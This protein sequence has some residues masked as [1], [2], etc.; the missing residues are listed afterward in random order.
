[1]EA[2]EFITTEDAPHRRIPTINADA[3]RPFDC[4][5]EGRALVTDQFWLLVGICLV[6][7]LIAGMAPL[8]LLYGP[9]HCGIA[10]CFLRLKNGEPLEFSHMFRGFDHFGSGF[11]VGLAEMLPA[12][13]VAIPVYVIAILGNILWFMRTDAGTPTGDPGGY[14]MVGFIVT[15][16]LVVSVS[17]VTHLIFA[18]SFPLVVEWKLPPGQALK[19][20]VRAVR[21]NLSGTIGLFFLTALVSLAGLLLF[22]IGI[23]LALPLVHAAWTVA[24]RKVFPP[25]PHH[26][27]TPPDPPIWREWHPDAVVAT[28]STGA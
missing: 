27:D 17:A 9:M 5:S 22:G 13:L 23:Y 20:S 11:V 24:Y 26:L 15:W 3:I 7:N 8:Y 25:Y 4:L 18:F 10:Y 14:L 6:A 1:M 16:I 28:G 12:L 2:T 19:L 21:A